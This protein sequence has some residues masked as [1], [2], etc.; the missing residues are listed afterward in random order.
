MIIAVL[1]FFNYVKKMDLPEDNKNPTVSVY[2]ST[3]AINCEYEG[4]T[5][6][7]SAEK[8]REAQV[9]V[10]SSRCGEKIDTIY[11]NECGTK[12]GVINI[13]KIYSEQLPEARRLEYMQLSDLKTDS[14]VNQYLLV[15]C[16][17]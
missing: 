6:K 12:A 9:Q 15:K 5:I 1:F 8:L 13:H 11:T 17:K 3:A 14:G 2:T 10:L 4:I 7:Q 16:K